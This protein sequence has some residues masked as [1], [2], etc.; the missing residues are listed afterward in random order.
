M[1]WGPERPCSDQV[2]QQFPTVADQVLFLVDDL[3][4]GL[5]NLPLKV[6]SKI[7]VCIQLLFMP[8]SCVFVLFFVWV[9]FLVAFAHVFKLCW[10]R[11]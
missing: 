7:K 3:G 6:G 5:W 10:F 4:S 11:H 8:V 9:V 2:S 1:V